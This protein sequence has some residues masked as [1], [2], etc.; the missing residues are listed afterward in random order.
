VGVRVLAE[1][2][3]K[4][5]GQ[6]FLVENRPG[7]NG[8][9]GMAAAAKS[10][11]DGYTLVTGGLGVNAMNL[12]LFTTAQMGFDPLKDVEPIILMAKLPF[13]IAV[14]PTFPASNMQELVAA[15]KAKPGSVNVA[16]TQTT[17]RM[18]VELFGRTT[19]APLF[20]VPYKAAGPAMSDVMSGIVSVAA[21][22]IAAL[23]PHVSSGRVKPIAVTSRKTS[24]LLPNVS[25]VLEQG[26]GDLEFVGWISM[27]G[28]RGMPREAVA[29]V[30]AE[31]NKALA[32]PDTRKRFL[33]LGFEPSGGT[34]QDL[35]DFEN[36]ERRRWGPL[37][38]SANIT[39]E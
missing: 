25:S 8:N 10:A 35:V 29:L 24:E 11:P 21:E 31:L 7:A 27:Y 18:L 20:V 36:S 9:I 16:V 2:M 4:S 37:I 1:H 23:R 15:I 12:F 33:D 22:T 34:V 19:G 26:G 28:P 17:S 13:L 3:T 38:K 14:S 39:A 5:V 32:L 6:T 30:N